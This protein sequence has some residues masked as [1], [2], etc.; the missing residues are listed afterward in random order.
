MRMARGGAVGDHGDGQIGGV[1]GSVEHLDVEDGGEAAES[2]GADAEAVDLVV[3]LDAEFFSS[4]LRAA[5]DEVLNVDGVHEGLLGEEHGFF[6][7]AADADAEH[8]PG[9]TSRRPWWARF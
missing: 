3:K 4:G 7:G 6:G 1:C 9:G 5:G 8:S 2:L